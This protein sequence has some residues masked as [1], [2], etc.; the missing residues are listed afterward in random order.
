MSR[1]PRIDAYIAKSADFAKPILEYLRGV[2]HA[3]V[4]DVEETMKW[5]MPFFDYHGP[6]CN[7]AAFKGHCVFHFWQQRETSL[8]RFTSI[9]DLPPKRELMRLIRD[10][11]K[12]NEQGIKH[13]PKR[14]PK[15]PVEMPADFAAALAKSKKARTAFE[16]FSPT[17]RR[18]YIEWIADAKT[19]A[20]RRRRMQQAMEWIAEGK[21]RNW[22]YQR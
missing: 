9:D 7:M 10:V 1:D 17:N 11:A 22:K 6:V 14:A 4:P 15:P 13:R 5:S 12:R 20:T 16:A 8:D 18:E 21:S 2:V 3:A 19:D